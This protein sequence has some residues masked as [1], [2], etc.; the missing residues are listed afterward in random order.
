MA[1][2]MKGLIQFITEIRNSKEEDAERRI[3]QREIVHIQKQFQQLNLSGYHK[4][5]YICKLLYVYLMGYRLTFGFDQAVELTRSDAFS[6]KAIGYLAINFYIGQVSEPQWDL[7]ERSID[8]DLASP[9]VDAMCLAL[10]AL[11]DLCCRRPE[12]AERYEQ[13]VYSAMCS[14]EFGIAVKKKAVLVMNR[15]VQVDGEIVARHPEIV[16]HAIPLVTSEDPSMCL[17][18]VPLLETITKLDHEATQSCTTLIID[19]LHQIVVQRVCPRDCYFHEVPCPWTVVKMLHLLEILIPDTSSAAEIE[20]ADRERL[21]EVLKSATTSSLHTSGSPGSSSECRKVSGAILFGA[22]SL[23]AHITPHTSPSSSI[24]D[25]DTLCTLLRSTDV[26][27]RYLAVGALMQIAA[28]GDSESVGAISRHFDLIFTLLR[29]RDVSIRRRALDLVYMAANSTNIEHV[30]TQL[31]EYLAIAEFSIK[32]EVAVKVALLAEK[33]ATDASWFVV[34]ILRLLALAGNYVDEDV[35]HRMAQ[36][37]VN[38]RSIQPT[39]CRAVVRCLKAD[40]YPQ[41]MLKLAAFVLSEFGDQIQAKTPIP[42]QFQLLSARYSQSSVATRAVLL[43]AFFKMYFKCE[44]VRPA[45]ARILQRETNV[46]NSEIQQRALEYSALIRLDHTDYLDHIVVAMPPF[47]A[48]VSPL[49]RRLGTVSTLQQSFKVPVPK[50][51]EIQ[52]L[53]TPNEA[54]N[55]DKSLKNSLHQLPNGSSRSLLLTSEA[56]LI[57]ASL[58]GSSSSSTHSRRPMKT[59]PVPPTSRRPTKS[60]MEPTDSRE[61]NISATSRHKDPVLSPNWRDGYYR[62]C[63]FD[64]GI[65]FEN[66]LIRIVYRLKR[67]KCALHLSITYSNKSPSAISGL[68]CKFSVPETVKEA[69]L[70]TLSVIQN[71]QSTISQGAKTTQFVDILVRMPYT[72]SDLPTLGI[73][74]MSGGLISLK[75]KLPVPLFKTLCPGAP[76]S[77]GIFQMRWSQIGQVLKD[78][79]S[80]DKT[81]RLQHPTDVQAIRRLTRLLGV[82]NLPQV[83]STPL[84][85]ASAGILNMHTANSGCLM[86]IDLDP[87]TNTFLHVTIRCTKPGIVA[88]LLAS[89][90]DLFSNEL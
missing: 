43:S 35:W 88:I 24:L 84:T 73:N 5:K 21:Q 44:K 38:N 20:P 36:I 64:Q 75:L 42:E 86:R 18:A 33:Y 30:C 53:S 67:T 65:F 48:K 9:R 66:A 79:G 39:A 52:H 50:E 41:P 55:A 87:E 56:K 4:K 51:A 19:K 80:A 28:R 7:V 90:C 14:P 57:S 61:T 78:D 6:E 13:R 71:P 29:D 22:L 3:I 32:S 23:G 54:Q 70:Y 85:I 2:Q 47:A 37:V 27:T 68:L 60:Q 69:G 12:I 58:T 25:T 15:L 81:V 89:F 49:L 82:N 72:D 76:L 34:T 77:S 45:V 74:F 1:P 16:T 63:R 83:A 17:A 62:L 31:L 59:P 26:N 40:K 46:F 8:A 10:Q 11:C